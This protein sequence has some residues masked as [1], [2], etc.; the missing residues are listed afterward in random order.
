MAISPNPVMRVK[1]SEDDCIR[2]NGEAIVEVCVTLFASIIDV[3]NVVV[4]GIYRYFD[5]LVFD[6][7]DD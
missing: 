7:V 2:I 5:D 6:S 3:N 1:V 4:S